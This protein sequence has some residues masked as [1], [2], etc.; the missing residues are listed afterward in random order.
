M[1]LDGPFDLTV[2]KVIK[3]LEEERPEGDTPREF[4]A[5]PPF[6]LS[7][8]ALQSRQY[9]SGEGLPGDDLGQLE[10]WRCGGNV[11]GHGRHA[12][13]GVEPRETDAHGDAVSMAWVLMMLA[14]DHE[15]II[16]PEQFQPLTLWLVSIPIS[17]QRLVKN[18]PTLS[19]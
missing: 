12:A 10:Q 13:W 18:K 2:G 14:G 6:P 7:C 16:F 9:H 3:P 8:G 4:S 15:G 17:R 1:V 11:D 19:N 5:E